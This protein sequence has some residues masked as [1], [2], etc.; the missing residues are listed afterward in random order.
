MRDETHAH[1]EIV[2]RTVTP[3]PAVQA[4]VDEAVD[5]VGPDR[6]PAGRHDHREHRPGRRAVRGD[7]RSAT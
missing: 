6:Q 1:N 3:D 4:I 5:Q 2:T 7:A